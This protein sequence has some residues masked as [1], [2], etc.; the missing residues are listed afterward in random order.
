MENILLI[1]FFL[2]V[3][4]MLVHFAFNVVR[5]GGF[6]E[7]IFN[8]SIIDT[9]GNVQIET[10]KHSSQV[11]SIHTLKRDTESLIGIEITSR[12]IGNYEMMTLVLSMDQAKQLGTYLNQASDTLEK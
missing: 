11:I 4:A 3:G 12:A 8:A 7:A 6:K 1:L 10:G 2:A 5:R 9:V